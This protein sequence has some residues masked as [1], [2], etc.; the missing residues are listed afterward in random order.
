MRILIITYDWPPRN[1]IASHRPYSWAKYW[2]EKGNNVTILTAQK[3]DFDKPLDL[4]LPPIDNIKIIETVYGNKKIQTI[5]NFF[6]GYFLNVLKRFKKYISK[7][8]TINV[9]IRYNWYKDIKLNINLNNISFDFD[10]VVSTYGPEAAH[11]IAFE[12]KNINPNIIWLADYRDLWSISHMLKLPNFLIRKIQKKELNIVGKNA[13]LITTVS[14]ELTYDLSKFFNK[15]VYNITNG[16]DLTFET[17]NSRILKNRINKVKEVKIVYTGMLYQGYR[18]PTPI[19]K[20]VELINKIDK[21]KDI[22]KIYFYGTSST[23]ID[24]FISN[25]NSSFIIKGGHLPQDIAIKMQLDADF[26]LL[27]ESSSENAKG[28]LTGKIFEYMASGNPI[29]S[30]G[31]KKNSAI[32]KILIETKSGKSYENDINDL[33]NDII[34]YINTSNIDW[35]KPDVNEIFKYSRKIIADNLLQ[36]IYN[37]KNNNEN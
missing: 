23:S 12:I 4:V 19:I 21:Y 2:S 25:Q 5:P 26:L 30:L 9:D 3:K 13:N 20:A 22:V 7:Y 35:F 31:S 15:E 1:S 34:N 33:M 28:V 14:N 37:Y 11:L 27:L 10:I 24:E 18:D 17:L 6:N 29:L 8:I 16:F 32:S 36:I